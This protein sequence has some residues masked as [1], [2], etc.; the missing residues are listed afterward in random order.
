[1]QNLVSDFDQA[2]IAL[3]NDLPLET[4]I[5]AY[6]D[7]RFKSLN[8]LNEQEVKE[9]MRFVKTEYNRVESEKESG[10]CE[11]EVIEV[12][13][14][15]NDAEK[16]EIE[17]REK[18]RGLIG[19]FMASRKKRYKSETE[20]ERYFALPEIDWCDDV[21]QW[22]A[23]NRG[24]YPI[25]SQLVKKYLGI[26]ASQASTERTFSTGGRVLSDTRRKTRP[27]LLEEQIFAHQNIKFK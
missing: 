24:R 20:L 12:S 25:L 2:F 15:D 19:L 17:M 3:W 16:R 26:P 8:F 18:K 10:V 11:L 14:D 1:M 23:V 6:L 4:M 7:P 5:V 21:L 22:W 13:D 9:T 27:A